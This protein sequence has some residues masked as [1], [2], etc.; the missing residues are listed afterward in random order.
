MREI[1]YGDKPDIVKWAAVK[2]IADRAGTKKVLQVLFYRPDLLSVESATG[3][4][5]AVAKRR[6]PCQV[7]RHV[8]KS[9]TRAIDLGN[10][11]GLDVA[12]IDDV[13][14]TARRSEYIQ[15]VVGCIMSFRKL[16][17]LLDPDTGI[18]AQRPDRGHVTRREI[19]IIWS[20]MRSQM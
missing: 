4:R 18:E 3:N 10:D 13:F 8:G 7:Y 16:V 19:G 17:V 12:L 5:R 9:L 11:L 14:D 6:I 20:S 2:E 1:W 15:A